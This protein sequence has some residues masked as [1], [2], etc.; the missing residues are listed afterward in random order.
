MGTDKNDEEPFK[1]K[2]RGK[3]HVPLPAFALYVLTTTW[4]ADP[5][6]LLRVQPVEFPAELSL[7][8]LERRKLHQRILQARSCS[9][10]TRKIC[11]K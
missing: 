1:Q 11:K 10:P 7:G 5:E 6:H 9:V 3:K 8:D 2:C 4:S